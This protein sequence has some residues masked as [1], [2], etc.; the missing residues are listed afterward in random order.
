MRKAAHV[1]AVSQREGVS[2]VAGILDALPRHLLR[3]VGKAKT[4]NR[5]QFV[6]ALERG[7]RLARHGFMEPNAPRR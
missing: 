6:S 1:Q 5:E 3:L 4:R 2:Q 7:L